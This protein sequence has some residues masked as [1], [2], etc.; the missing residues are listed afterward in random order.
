VFLILEHAGLGDTLGRT[1]RPL[2]H[3]YA[4]VAVVAGWVLFRCDTLVHAGAFYL[5]LVGGGAPTQLRYP[6]LMYL[7]PLVATTL[8]VA[9]IGSMPIGRVLAAAVDRRATI[10]PALGTAAFAIEWMWLASALIASCAYM[11]AGTYN[12]FIYFRF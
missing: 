1:W 5:A 11:A 10:H 2:R 7:D 9:V 8:A 6:L 4:L 3:A 12:P